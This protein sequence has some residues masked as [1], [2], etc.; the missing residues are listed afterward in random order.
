MS[1]WPALLWR[2]PHR[3]FHSHLHQHGHVFQAPRMHEFTYQLRCGQHVPKFTSHVRGGAVP[4][5]GQSRFPQQSTR[6][7][8]DPHMVAAAWPGVVLGT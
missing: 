8:A 3:A 2:V 4:G 1:H 7:G 6:T 5:N